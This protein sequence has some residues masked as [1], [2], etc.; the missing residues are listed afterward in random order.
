[1]QCVILYRSKLNGAVGFIGDGTT[2]ATE[3]NLAV[4]ESRGDAI[5]YVD[6]SPFLRAVPHQIVELEDI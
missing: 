2:D 3:G 6:Q 4:F 1:M 5:D